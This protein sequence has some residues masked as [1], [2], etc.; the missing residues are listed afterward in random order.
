VTFAEMARYAE[1]HVIFIMLTLGVIRT[2]VL[3]I[4]QLLTL[5]IPA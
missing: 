1:R 2:L 3:Y 5:I 4:S